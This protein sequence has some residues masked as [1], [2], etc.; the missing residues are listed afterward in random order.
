MNPILWASD[1]LFTLFPLDAFGKSCKFIGG[2]SETETPPRH[3]VYQGGVFLR[4]KVCRRLL[5]LIIPR[6]KGS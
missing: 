4:R 1:I 5:I 3:I 2:T 6:S